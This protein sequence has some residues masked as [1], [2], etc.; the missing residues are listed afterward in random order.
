M[1]KHF[2]LL[3][4]LLMACGTAS[5]QKTHYQGEVVINYGFGVGDVQLARTG[6]HMINGIRFNPYLSAGVGIGVAIPM[7]EMKNPTSRSPCT[8]T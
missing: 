5:A 3:A 8:S 6:V 2:L 4:L 1:K 7:Q